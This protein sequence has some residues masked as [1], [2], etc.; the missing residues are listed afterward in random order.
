MSLTAKFFSASRCKP[1][2]SRSKAEDHARWLDR[3][4][5]EVEDLLVPYPAEGMVAYPLAGE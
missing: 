2:R 3:E 4:N 5:G 1:P